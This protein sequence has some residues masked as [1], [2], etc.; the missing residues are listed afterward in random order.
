MLRKLSLHGAMSKPR[1]SDESS[2]ASARVRVQKSLRQGGRGKAAATATS[3]LLS[4]GV[5]APRDLDD[6]NAED[7]SED[8]SQIASLLQTFSSL[9]NQ[10]KKLQTTGQRKAQGSMVLPDIPEKISLED[11]SVKACCIEDIVY[12]SSQNWS[13]LTNSAI[14][15]FTDQT[16]RAGASNSSL[17]DSSLTDSSSTLTVDTELGG[18]PSESRRSQRREARAAGSPSGAFP[19]GV[20]HRHLELQGVS[21][22]AFHALLDYMYTG[23]LHLTCQNIGKLYVTASILKIASVKKKCARILTKSPYDPKHAVYVYVT[24]RKYGLASVCKRA[25]KLL[26][27]RLEETVTCK[28]F[29]DLDV[30]QVCEV[31][32]GNTVGARGE[33][34]MFLAALHWLNHNYLENEPYVLKVMQCVRFGTMSIEELLCCLHPPLLPGIMEVHEVRAHILAALCY[35]VAAMYNQQ[36]LFPAP[37]LKARYFKLDGPIT[38]WDLNLFSTIKN[39]PAAAPPVTYPKYLNDASAN[40]LRK[41]PPLTIQFPAQRE[42]VFHG[43]PLADYLL[44]NRAEIPL[45]AWSDD[46]YEGLGACGSG[47]HAR[48]PRSPVLLVV[49]GFDPDAPGDTAVGTKILRYHVEKNVWEKLESFPMPRHHHCAVLHRDKLY[50]TGGYDNYQTTQS[51]L[52][53]TSVCFSYDLTKKLWQPLPNMARSRAYHAAACFDGTLFVVGGRSSKGE[54]LS[55]VEALCLEERRQWQ[56]LPCRLCRPRMAA[57]S[58]Q[59]GGHLWLAGGLTDSRAGLV[60]ISDVDC[61]DPSSCEFCFHVSFLPTPRCFFSLVAVDGRLFALGG[62]SVKDNEL[63]SLGDVWSC[64]DHC[65]E[66]RGTFD[67]G[68]HDVGTVAYGDS[69]YMVGGLSSDTKSGIRAVSCYRTALNTFTPSLAPLPR[70]LCG[71]AVV[72]LA[73]MD[74]GV[75]DS[76]GGDCKRWA[77]NPRAGGGGSDVES[78]PFPNVGRCTRV[79]PVTDSGR[80][81]SAGSPPPRR[82]RPGPPP[83]QGDPWVTWRRTSAERPSSIVSEPTTAAGPAERAQQTQQSPPRCAHSEY[84]RLEAN[85]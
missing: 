49:G 83:N 79:E 23:K 32:S 28:P 45:S 20:G 66:R 60:V 42:P 71:A 37:Q 36:H 46:P 5:T 18:Q 34:V 72:V 15:T 39:P 9:S 78:E 13:Y 47:A 82:A 16:S 67:Q 44:R 54:I 30:N 27:H 24:A 40:I 52:E 73:P 10:G 7:G 25:L 35:K 59:M 58:T 84:R 8:F 55:S 70:A 22:D 12:P 53:P 33:M 43:D 64:L 41:A 17:F 6:L 29:L 19:R 61:F 26:H 3:S 4:Q 80:S 77:A 74:L 69:V 38:L 75:A 63:D 2:R 21:G 48:D 68:Y 14:T 62:C 1:G 56:E 50:I 65:W 31:L 57:G 51:N 11:W 81:S 85:K 76:T